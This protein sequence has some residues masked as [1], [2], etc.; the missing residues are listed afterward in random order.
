MFDTLLDVATREF[1]DSRSGSEDVEVLDLSV[2]RNPPQSP[3]VS[4]HP[5]PLAT[6]TSVS[7]DHQTTLLIP[8]TKEIEKKRQQLLQLQ[9][10]AY[11]QQ[12]LQRKK[13]KQ[14]LEQLRQ[15]QRE[16]QPHEEPPQEKQPAV[17]KTVEARTEKRPVKVLTVLDLP[18]IDEEELEADP[19]LPKK[20]N[21]FE[22]HFFNRNRYTVEVCYRICLFKQNRIQKNW[23]ERKVIIG[24][25]TRAGRGK[26]A[27]CPPTA[28]AKQVHKM[29]LTGKTELKLILKVKRKAYE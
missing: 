23:R 7:V 19:A 20:P 25:S 26:R 4:N 16:Q 10:E 12:T 18:P 22:F 13:E 28:E 24:K 6:P 2:K 5:T 29:F 27:H 3:L 15:L 17:P 14:H 1:R 8:H 11:E 21:T 9:Q